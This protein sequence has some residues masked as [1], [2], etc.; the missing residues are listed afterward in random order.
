MRRDDSTPGKLLDGRGVRSQYFG[1]S[2]FAKMSVVSEK[3]VFKCPY[4]ESKGIYAPL[5]CD[6]QT[7]AGTIFKVLKPE[8][9]RHLRHRWRSLA[10]VMAAS[11][12][13]VQ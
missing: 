12:L 3:C 13:G 7:G 1:Q 9:E 8:P 11:G 5:G 6:I 10:A 4:L 2:S